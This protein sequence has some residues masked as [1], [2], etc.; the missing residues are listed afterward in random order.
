MTMNSKHQKESTR[1]PDF[2][3]DSRYQSKKEAASEATS[4]MEARLEKMKNLSKDQ[5]I[6]AKLIQLKLKMEEYLKQPQYD[7][8]NYFSYFLKEYIDT[9]YS[10]RKGFARDIN[11]SPIRLSQ[12]INNHRDPQDEFILKL[13]IHSEMVFE[14]IC[15]FQKM[16]WYQVFFHDKVCNTMMNQEEWRSKIEKDVNLSEPI[17]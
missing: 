2:G 5:I 7:G 6:R 17:S 14:N 13:M 16:T 9:I 10:T 12:V 8:S 4:L 15:S 1:D 3:L 11:V